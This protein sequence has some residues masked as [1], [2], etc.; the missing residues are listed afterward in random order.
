MVAIALSMF[1]ALFAFGEQ[2]LGYSDPHGRVQFA[3]FIAF[4]LG[5][6]CGYR[7]RS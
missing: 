3:I 7:T 6:L 5:V 1:I 2:L 4:V